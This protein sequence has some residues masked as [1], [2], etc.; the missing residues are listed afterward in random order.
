KRRYEGSN[1]RIAFDVFT[2]Q[3]R[4]NGRHFTIRRVSAD[5]WAEQCNDAEIS[6]AARFS[7]RIERERQPNVD[8]LRRGP[9]VGKAAGDR[10]P[11]AAHRDGAADDRL[12][13]TESP[14]REA[15]RHDGNGLGAAHSIGIL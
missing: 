15:A 13:A 9:P 3:F 12:S 14:L 7:K 8:E 11:R 10:A 2:A 6:V 1:V 5:V 4:A